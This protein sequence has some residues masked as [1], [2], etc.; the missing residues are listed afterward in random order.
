MVNL[1]KVFLN[2]LPYI[3]KALN[4]ML[5]GKLV[6]EAILSMRLNVRGVEAILM[7]SN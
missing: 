7:L 4:T 6:L 5:K 1:Y 3:G 2:L